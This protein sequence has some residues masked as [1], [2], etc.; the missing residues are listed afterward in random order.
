MSQIFNKRWAA[1]IGFS[2]LLSLLF[3]NCGQPGAISK[4]LAQAEVITEVVIDEVIQNCNQARSSGQLKVHQELVRFEDTKVESG[5]NQVCQFAPSN[6]EVNGNLPM[7]EGVLR[8]R[9]DQSHQL[10]LPKGAVIC[11]VKMTNSLQ[12]FRYDDNFFFTLNGFLL[13]SNNKTAVQKGLVPG[14]LQFANKNIP[15]F[16]YDWLGVRDQSFK[17]VADDYC[18]GGDQSEATCQWPVT[19]KQ[20]SIR[21]EFSQALLVAMSL[22]TPSDQQTFGFSITGDNDPNIDCYHERLDFSMSVDYY[23]PVK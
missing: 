4:P 15:V 23:I 20:G 7:K 19:E 8:A 21:F 2:L 12:S 9:Y 5:R 17:N 6:T 14:N 11:D 10:K 22:G 13:A 16:K 18:L 1:F 3:T